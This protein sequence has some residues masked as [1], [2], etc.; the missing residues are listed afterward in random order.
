LGLS[1]SR[2]RP[3]LFRDRRDAGRI[4][5]ERLRRFAGRPDAIVLGLPRGGVEVAYEVA[6]ALDLPLDVLV[7]RKLGVPGHEELAFGAIAQ[8]V[9]VLDEIAGALTISEDTVHRIASEEERELERR[10]RLFREGRAAHDLRGRFVLLVDDGLAT[11][12][13]MR[14]AARAVRAHEPAG[15]VIAVPVAAPATCADLASEADEI[16]CLATPE[17]FHAVGQWY[18]DFAQTSDEEVRKLLAAA[19]QRELS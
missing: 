10:E 7:V 6:F 19:F 18:Q 3:V 13:T 9:L 8:G 12:S 5:G 2:I 11:G 17:P 1:V 4:L 14:A 16:V 15:L